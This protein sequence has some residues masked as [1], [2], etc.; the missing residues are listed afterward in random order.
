MLYIKIKFKII[1]EGQPYFFIYN[2]K[3]KIYDNNRNNKIKN[4]Q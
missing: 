3:Q 4:E 1:L 2:N